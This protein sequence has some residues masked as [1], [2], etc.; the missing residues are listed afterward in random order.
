M[1]KILF[2]LLL[3]LQ[4]LM[5]DILGGELSLGMYGHSPSGYA[6]YTPQDGTQET[7]ANLDD[8]FRW[9]DNNDIFFK[10]YLEHPLPFMP[11]LKLGYTKLG[12]KG[13][14]TV[15]LFSWGDIGTYSGEIDSTLGLNMTDATLYYELLDN[16]VEFDAGLTMR[17]AK[18]SIDVTTPLQKESVDF[19]TWIP[20]VY[21]KTRFNIPA[22]D[23][24]LQLEAN[25]V[26]YE[27]TTFYDYELSARYTFTM[28][29]GLEAGY[30]ALHLNSDDL[31]SGLTTDM[32]F[33]GPFAAFVWDF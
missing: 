20:M 8:T 10:A 18:G 5:A 15:S 24:S 23:V 14:N 29:L 21:A 19:S 17:Y 16:W 12:Y 28:G 9:G 7:S 22:T 6:S 32:D 26:S 1:K 25:A 2:I 31:T 13:T 33:S 4:T 27:G 3:T 30:K 11:N